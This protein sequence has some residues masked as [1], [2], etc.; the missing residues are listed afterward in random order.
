MMGRF[1]FLESCTGVDTYSDRSRPNAPVESL[2]TTR[3][4]GSLHERVV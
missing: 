1:P 4:V 2:G 3:L